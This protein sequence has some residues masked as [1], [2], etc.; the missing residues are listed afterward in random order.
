MCFLTNFMEEELIHQQNEEFFRRR[1]NQLN[2]DQWEEQHHIEEMAYELWAQ[3]QYDNLQIM[4]LEG[5]LPSVIEGDPIIAE[6]AIETSIE[7]MKE[8]IHFEY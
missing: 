1:Q 4:E 7:D 2:A 3:E 5:I 6:P 8:L